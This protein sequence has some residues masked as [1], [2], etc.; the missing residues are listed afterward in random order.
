MGTD[1]PIGDK[2]HVLNWKKKMIF[3]KVIKIRVKVRHVVVMVRVKL[4]EIN[5]RLCSDE[6]G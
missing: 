1:Y 3:G 4:Q 6:I 5:L 2:N